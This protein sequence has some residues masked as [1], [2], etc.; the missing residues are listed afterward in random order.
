MQMVMFVLDD[1]DMLD[2]VLDGWRAIGVSG[3][4]IFETSGQYRRQQQTRPVG[5]RYAFGLPR[6]LRSEMGNYTLFA[7]VPDEATVRACLAAAERVVGDL[8]GPDT[9][10]LASWELTVVKGVPQELLMR[11]EGDR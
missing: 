5:A 6:G 7:V 4:T 1:P 2:A 8:D 10:V 11:G 9:G 3:A